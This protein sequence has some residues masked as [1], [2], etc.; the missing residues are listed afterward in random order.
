MVSSVF[1]WALAGFLSEGGGEIL[2]GFEAELQSNVDDGSVGLSEK[3]FGFFHSLG[4]EP[5][6][7]SLTKNFMEDAGHPDL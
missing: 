6:A 5:L 1:S 3:L 7:R 2:T 4:S